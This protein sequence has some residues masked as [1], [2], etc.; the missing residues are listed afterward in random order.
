MAESYN[1]KY[2]SDYRN[3][4]S[5]YNSK[6]VSKNYNRKSR[7]DQVKE[8]KVMPRFSSPTRNFCEH[9]DHQHRQSCCVYYH[10]T[11]ENALMYSLFKEELEMEKTRFY[12]YGLVDPDIVSGGITPGGFPEFTNTEEMNLKEESECYKQPEIRLYSPLFAMLNLS[13]DKVA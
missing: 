9:C 12:K 4:F 3:R 1:K 2:F 13:F 6:K 7:R 8:N 5:K 11:T 10:E